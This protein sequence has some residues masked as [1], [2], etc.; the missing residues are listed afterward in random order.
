MRIATLAVLAL[1]LSACSNEREGESAEDYAARVGTGD[2]AAAPDP[3]T[4]SS[5][6]VASAVPANVPLVL[7][8]LGN[9]AGADLGP[10]DGGCTFLVTGRELLLAGA[11]DDPASRGKAVVRLG[12]KLYLLDAAPGGMPAIRK[13]PRFTGRG[14]SVTVRPTAGQKA[15]LEVVDAGGNAAHIAGDWICA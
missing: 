8:Q 6:P 3:A 10:R 12:G 15:D 11:P 14:L 4:Q 9:I 1:A 2:K 13:G 7:E 5:V